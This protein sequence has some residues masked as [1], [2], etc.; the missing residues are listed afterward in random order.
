MSF[1]NAIAISAMVVL[2]CALYGLGVAVRRWQGLP[3]G[4]W[5]M[6]V[7]LGLAVWIAIGGALNLLRVAYPVAIYSMLAVGCVVMAMH[8]R[9][10]KFDPQAIWPG[11]REERILESD[12]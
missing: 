11:A 1:A 12:A 2:G 5:P 6:T 10:I 9:A 7:A 4:T 3:I 8:V